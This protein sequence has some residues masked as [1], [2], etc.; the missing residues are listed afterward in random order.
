M[1]KTSTYAKTTENYWTLSM[2]ALS[3]GVSSANSGDY[4]G[5]SVYLN[6]CLEHAEH[7]EVDPAM[8]AHAH[9]ILAQ[10]QLERGATRE[11]LYHASRA[12]QEYR[13][14]GNIA[15]VASSASLLVSVNIELQ[16][17]EAARKVLSSI[18]IEE[19]TSV[20]LVS[21]LN[22]RAKLSCLDGNFD[23]A[24]VDHDRAISLAKEI[25][26]ERLRV[27]SI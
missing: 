5:A 11:A 26:N 18:N 15:R 12:L 23:D 6:R 20:Q 24:H 7:A 8:Q 4:D 27:N 3:L 2:I 13:A 19:A 10:A 25:G 22:L 9:L 1:Q 17:V 16:D 14:L 21:L